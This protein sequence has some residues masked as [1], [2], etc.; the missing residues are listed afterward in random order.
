[1]INDS[2]ISKREIHETQ[3]KHGQLATKQSTVVKFKRLKAHIAF[4]QSQI[5]CLRLRII[6]KAKILRRVTTSLDIT[7]CGT[8]AVV[9]PP[10]KINPF[11]SKDLTHFLSHLQLLHSNVQAVTQQIQNESHECP[12]RTWLRFID[13]EVIDVSSPSYIFTR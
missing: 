9:I 8:D 4:H 12:L 3:E 6:S 2:C 10:W 11:A 13:N 7:S 5:A 1:M